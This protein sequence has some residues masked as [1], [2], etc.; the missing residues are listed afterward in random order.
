MN[1][2]VSKQIC[3]NNIVIV[4]RKDLDIVPHDY[5][6]VLRWVYNSKY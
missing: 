2:K 4:E 5:W 3:I 1:Q 6:S